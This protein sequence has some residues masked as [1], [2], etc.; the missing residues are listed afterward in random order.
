MIQTSRAPYGHEVF[1]TLFGTAT[2][3]VLLSSPDGRFVEVNDAARQLLEGTG[4]D[5]GDA[6]LLDLLLHTP[7]P[8]TEREDWSAALAELGDGD[9]T[10]PVRTNL[11]LAPAGST[12]RIVQVTTAP[13]TLAG[14][15]YLISHLEDATGRR[16]QEQRLVY[17]ATHDAAT[18]LPNRELVHQRLVAALTRSRQ[19]GL[20]VAAL[21]I[22]LDDYDA[23][24][25]EHGTH[26]GDVLLGTVGHRLRSVLRSGDSAGRWTG[27]EFL[28]VACDVD[29]PEALAELVRRL[30]NKLARPVS[31]GPPPDPNAERGAAPPVTTTVPVSVRIG[32]ALSRDGEQPAPLI[33][34]AEASRYAKIRARRRAGGTRAAAGRPTPRTPVQRGAGTT[35]GLQPNAAMRD[36][37]H[38]TLLCEQAVVAE[39]R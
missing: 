35:L 32:A 7:E 17:L 23:L 1:R 21:S 20:P 31:L 18:G 27:A 15:T 19:T 24:V 37:R 30:E 12:P 29:G 2:S 34:R 10:S 26:L 9:R 11:G 3:A 28:V 8:A 5:L 33:R 38:E 4:I 14:T 25:A 13:V 36:D 39:Q 22:T 6:E 16:L